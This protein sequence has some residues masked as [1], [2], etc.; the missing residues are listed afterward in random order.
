MKRTQINLQKYLAIG[1]LFFATACSKNETE[2]R[3][4]VQAEDG[5][6][7][8]NQATNGQTSTFNNG[9][10]LLDVNY[11]NGTS[12]S[13]ITGVTATHAQAADA[14]Y[15]ITPAE[16]GS[17]YAIAHKIVY[18]DPAYLSDEAIR[19]ESD[20][21]AIPA[22]Q[23]F[24]GDE[25]RYEFSVLLKDWTPWVSGPTHETTVFQLKVS[26]N[27]TSGSGVP[28]QFRTAR[29]AMR[30][31][32]TGSSS[33]KDIIPNLQL[34]KNQWMHFRVDVLWADNATGYMKTYMKLPGQSSYVL[35]D[36]KNNYRT[37]DGNV[38][39]GNKG[40][41][42]WGVY[43]TQE[44]LTRIAYHDNIRIIKLPLQ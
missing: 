1:L 38:A 25:R 34:Y 35:V 36:E 44:G 37:F 40:Y 2:L 43:V 9:D 42:K 21:V 32:Y 7:A 8:R 6:L 39:V 29:N 18:G 30:L 31:R 24:P 20:A 14:A 3:N 22:A 16:N 19:S 10:V 23:F 27:S 41:I 13:G 33:I 5:N 12:S 4:P 26:G 28:L 17:N 15:M 11:E